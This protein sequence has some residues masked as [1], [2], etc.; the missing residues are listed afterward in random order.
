MVRSGPSPDSQWAGLGV[1]LVGRR[2]H[3]LCV[4]D[5]AQF[6]P[7]TTVTL[8]LGLMCRPLDAR[9]SHDF[10][11]DTDSGAPCFPPEEP[12]TS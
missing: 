8:S 2:R 10:V 1:A 9:P 6:E 12:M 4:L 5:G 7:G 3:L 11:S